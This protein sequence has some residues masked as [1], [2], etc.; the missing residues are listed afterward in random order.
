MKID[1]ESIEKLIEEASLKAPVG[2]ITAYNAERVADLALEKAA[3]LAEV[4][5]DAGY[6]IR[7]L[8]TTI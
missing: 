5:V 4:T 6:A 3:S 7:E 8:K 1:K 2:G